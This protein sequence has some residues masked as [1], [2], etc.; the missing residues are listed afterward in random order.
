MLDAWYADRPEVRQWQAET[1]ATAHRTGWTRTLMGRYRKLGGIQD[2]TRA[3]VS[4]MERASINTPIQ[5]GAADVMTL[6]MLKI[7]RSQKLK[8]LGYT[9]LLQIHDEVIL[10]G[11]EEHALAAKEEV[12]ACMEHPFDEALPSLQVDLVVDAK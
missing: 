6:A 5:G 8:E 10:E 11:P 2:G 9:L 7:A 3:V 4:H 12:V 1:I